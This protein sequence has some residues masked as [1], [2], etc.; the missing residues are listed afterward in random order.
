MPT[1]GDRRHW[2][3]VYTEKDPSQVSWY[4]PVLERSL[5]L[6]GEARLDHDAAI[7]DAGGGASTLA[8]DLLE[9]GY[10]DITVADI[11]GSSL[12]E[13]KAQLGESADRVTWIEADIRNHDFGRR[14][15]LWHD[16]ALF[17][18]MVEP[19]DRDAYVQTVRQTLRPGGHLLIATFGPDGPHRCSGLPVA[20]YGATELSQTIGD[21]FE[22]L[23]SG[24]EDHQTPSGN[25]QQFLYAN[26]R[27]VAD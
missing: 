25:D 26:L 7:L 14:F 18:F 3:R 2:Q 1:I 11:S 8:S 23:M 12:D 24:L 17:H 27:R 6:V 15:D 20:R 4:E 10:T 9:A 19:R 21:D 16:R 5:A 13:A 22:L